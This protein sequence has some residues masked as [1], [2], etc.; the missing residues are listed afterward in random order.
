MI[1]PVGPATV[2]STTAPTFG[3][4]LAAR[5]ADLAPAEQRVAEYLR[6]NLRDVIF[7]TAADIAATTETS[8]ATVIRT[9][10]AL[11]YSGLPELK[12]EVGLQVL[13]ATRATERLVE[14]ID[15]AG[16][17]PVSIVDH[18]FLE[19][20]ERLEETRRL[21]DEDAFKSAIG[22]I[23]QANEILA[24]GIGPSEFV[25]RYAALRLGRLGLKTRATG[26]TGFRLAD[27]LVSLRAEDAVLVYAPRRLLHDVDVLLSHAS[28][29]GAKVILVTDPFQRA[30]DERVHCL[31][32]AVH[33]PSGFSGEMLTAAAVT[34]TIVL[35]IATQEKTRA[36]ATF[37]QL[38]ELR[39]QIA[40]T[41]SGSVRRPRRGNHSR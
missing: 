29:V 35:A 39:Q 36:E 1:V 8:D 41:A 14:G 25:A 30:V 26:R 20:V 18:I 11:G 2:V 32:A 33:A 34:D 5:F 6:N 16:G 19:A 22:C 7:A 21:L 24:Y 15:R 12:Q 10:K 40:R 37:D 13:T 9:A 23:T 3:R 31:L 38:T 27:E 17:D 4:R 28:K